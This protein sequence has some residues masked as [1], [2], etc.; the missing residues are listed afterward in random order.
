MV[1]PDERRRFSTSAL[2]GT[3]VP[4]VESAPAPPPLEALERIVRAALAEDVGA[5]DLTTEAVVPRGRLCHADIVLEEPG[6]VCGLGVVAAVF[7]ALDASTAVAP[8]LGEGS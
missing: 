6:V 1:S 2:T 7:E 8:R 4:S 3:V 5:G